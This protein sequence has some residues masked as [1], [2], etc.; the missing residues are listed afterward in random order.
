M[1]KNLFGSLFLMFALVMPMLAQAPAKPARAPGSIVASRVR[2]DVSAKNTIDGTVA[3]LHD[4][5]KITENFTVTT[6][7]GGAVILM[8]SNGATVSMNE[9]SILNIQEFQQDPFSGPIKLADLKKEPSTSVTKLNMTRGEL[10]GKVVHLN[11]DGGSEFTIATP[12]GAAGIRGTTFQITFVPDG[13][14]NATFSLMTT[15][16]AVLFTKTGSVPLSVTTGLQIA[17]TVTVNDTTK[18]GT[19]T[20][21]LPSTTTTTAIS[22]ADL[23]SIAAAAQ[24]IITT[25]TNSNITVTPSNPTPTPA[26]APAP[27]PTPVIDNSAAL[28]QTPA[29]RVTNGDGTGT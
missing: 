1:M 9:D 24:T 26:P 3:T 28:P 14:G 11:V 8:F 5:D 10:V 21:T 7:K 4:G 12:V 29:S 19:A 23:A 2:G 18:T 13:N 20:A 17:A 16:G 27:A 6:A 22:A 25:V 15:E